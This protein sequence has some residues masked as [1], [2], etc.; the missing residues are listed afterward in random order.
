MN[1]RIHI[2]AL[3]TACLT[4]LTSG[5]IAALVRLLLLPDLPE[6]WPW[7]AIGI[8]AGYGALLGYAGIIAEYRKPPPQS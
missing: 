4:A 5:G 1:Q 2:L 3:T 7:L 6:P 8:S